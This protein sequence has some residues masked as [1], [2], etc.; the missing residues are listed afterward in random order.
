M[1]R[2]ERYCV[3]FGNEQANSTFCIL[4]FLHCSLVILTKI[5]YAYVRQAVAARCA[6]AAARPKLLI[7]MHRPCAAA[8]SQQAG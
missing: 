4:V 5:V 7:V 6:D 1:A 8:V 2:V 3:V